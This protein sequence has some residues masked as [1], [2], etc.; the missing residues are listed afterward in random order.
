MVKNIMDDSID[1][2]KMIWSFSYGLDIIMQAESPHHQDQLQRVQAEQEGEGVGRHLCLVGKEK[3]SAVKNWVIFC[4][5]HCLA[6][7]AA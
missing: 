4:P 7:Q 3:A 5:L 2:N 6:L 1:K